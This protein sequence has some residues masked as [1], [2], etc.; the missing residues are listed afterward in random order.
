MSFPMDESMSTRATSLA[1]ARDAATKGRVD[2]AD[3]AGVSSERRVRRAW[4]LRRCGR[5]AGSGE[6]GVSGVDSWSEMYYGGKDLMNV[7][8]RAMRD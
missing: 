5:C 6:P 2:D 3:A 1:W 8:I 7:R 4:M